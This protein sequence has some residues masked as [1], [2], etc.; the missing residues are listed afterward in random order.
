MLGVSN[1]CYALSYSMEDAAAATDFTTSVIFKCG[2]PE[3]LNYNVQ[4]IFVSTD[5]SSEAACDGYDK[6]VAD[7]QI[8]EA[9]PTTSC[10]AQ[11][12]SDGVTAYS[13]KFGTEDGTEIPT[14][15]F[16][17]DTPDCAATHLV[18]GVPTKTKTSTLELYTACEDQAW[19]GG[20]SVYGKWV[21]NFEYHPPPPTAVP[22]EAPSPTPSESPTPRPTDVGEYPGLEDWRPSHGQTD[23]S[24]GGTTINSGGDIGIGGGIGGDKPPE[25]EPEPSRDKGGK[26]GH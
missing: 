17:F 1:T 15:E 9:F 8:F 23:F 18:Q 19:Q 24:G 4:K 21:H 3:L 10:I 12:Q 6:N 11:R 22:T 26:G 14:M 13:L 5:T 7:G 25:P 20:I 2:T 16:S